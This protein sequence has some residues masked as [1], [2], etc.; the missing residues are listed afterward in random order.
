M[1]D[2][3]PDRPR[4]PSARV[5]ALVVGLALL[6]LVALLATRDTASNELRGADLI[7]NL[8]PPVVGLAIDGEAFDLDDLQGSWV[9][10]NFFAT[11]CAPCIRE[12]PELIEFSERH[13]TVGDRRVVGVVWG[14]DPAKVRD[15]FTERG[16]DWPVIT[17]PDGSIGVAYEV[18]AGA[19]TYI[20]APNG[21]VVEKLFSSVTADQL[22]AII[23][24]YE[25]VGS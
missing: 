19:E 11:W 15:F 13:A 24:S 1:T 21:V 6:G 3:S 18:V 16:G 23:D 14:D 10:L 25:V 4:G 8:A 20:V 9:A 5:I 12:H 17:D 7:G 22:D 2:P